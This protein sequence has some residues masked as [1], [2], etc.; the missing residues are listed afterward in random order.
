MQCGKF[1]LVPG[2]ETASTET[3]VLNDA[4]KSIES[5]DGFVLFDA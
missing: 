3:M 1:R 4:V 5:E 2:V